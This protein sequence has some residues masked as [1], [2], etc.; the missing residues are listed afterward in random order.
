MGRPASKLT[1]K[2]F[3]YLKVLERTDAVDKAARWLCI[4]VCGAVTKVRTNHLVNGQIISCG[5]KKGMQPLECLTQRGLS[6][7]AA[8]RSWQAMN[9][10]CTDIYYHA[11]HRYGGRGITVC[12]RWKVFL[13][14]LA[15]MGQPP[16]GYWLDRIDNNKGYYP[17]NCRWVTPKENANNRG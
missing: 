17:E 5:C 11:Y 6:R 4:C 15:D 3:G 10:R 9:R 13:N 12:D 1:G 2:T 16:T 7:S 14:F 8:Y